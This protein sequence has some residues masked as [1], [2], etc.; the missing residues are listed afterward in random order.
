MTQVPTLWNVA[1]AGTK[2]LASKCIQMLLHCIGMARAEGDQTI[3]QEEYE[4]QFQKIPAENKS[5][6][7]PRTLQK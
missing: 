6:H 4:V 5:M 1:D 7:L 3:G 2:P